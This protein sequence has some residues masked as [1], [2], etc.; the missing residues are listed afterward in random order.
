VPE[1]F[2]RTEVALLGEVDGPARHNRRQ[3]APGEAEKVAPTAAPVDVV[4]V[5]RGVGRPDP[6]AAFSGDS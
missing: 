2:L 5:P 4:E 3:A 6:R 1:P